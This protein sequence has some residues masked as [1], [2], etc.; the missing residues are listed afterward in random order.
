[1]KIKILIISVLLMVTSTAH[2]E[3]GKPWLMPGLPQQLYPE[4]VS[5]PQ[6][7]VAPASERYRFCCPEFHPPMFKRNPLYPPMLDPPLPMEEPPY[8]PHPK[9]DRFRREI[10]WEQLDDAFRNFGR[11]LGEGIANTLTAEPEK[12]TGWEQYP[13]LDCKKIGNAGDDENRDVID[14]S[15][16]NLPSYPKWLGIG[17]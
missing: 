9:E 3:I 10:P 6:W 1:M 11:S 2:T 16:K 14:C 7:I 8:Y 5:P 13:Y 12:Q 4:L 15:H 17:E